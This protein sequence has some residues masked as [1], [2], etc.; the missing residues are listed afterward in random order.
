MKLKV[1]IHQAED[2]GYWAQVPAIPGCATQWENVRELV[3]NVYDAVEGSLSI[4]TDTAQ[5][6]AT[7]HLV[8]LAVSHRYNQWQDGECRAGEETLD[9]SPHYA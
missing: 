9:F 2:G 4:D 6:E 8:E 1:I 7:D 3:G 5:P